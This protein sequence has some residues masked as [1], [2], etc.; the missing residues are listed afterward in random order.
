MVSFRNPFRALLQ[1]V[2]F[3]TYH[4]NF[5]ATMRGQ[6][7]VGEI[8]KERN[9]KERVMASTT[10]AAVFKRN[11]GTGET[12]TAAV[13]LP[14]LLPSSSFCPGESHFLGLT[15]GGENCTPEWVPVMLGPTQNYC[16]GENR[17][18]FSDPAA[19]DEPGTRNKKF[20]LS[21]F[22][23]WWRGIPVVNFGVTDREG[24]LYMSATNTEK[25]VRI[26]TV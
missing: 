18:Q 26:P 25:K 11:L 21:L 22:S 1:F 23:L 14:L 20:N 17:V 4:T 10:T 5:Y 24:L 13:F 7:T 19:A 15:W 6:P 8:P 16:R 9:G 12:A 3:L 2:V